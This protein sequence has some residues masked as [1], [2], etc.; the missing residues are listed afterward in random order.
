MSSHPVLI[1]ALGGTGKEVAKQ[2]RMRLQ[3]AYGDNE[4]IHEATRFLY[5]D[6]DVK[7]NEAFSKYQ[8]QAFPLTV[9]REV[10]AD[11]QKYNSY[12]IGRAHV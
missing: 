9:S 3:L 4:A 2:L 5:I 10:L 12:K 6:T 1:I 7:D 8:S 11:L